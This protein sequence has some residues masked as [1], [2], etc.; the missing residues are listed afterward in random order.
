M[1]C[2]VKGHNVDHCEMKP[3]EDNLPLLRASHG[4]RPCPTSLTRRGAEA[5]LAAGDRLADARLSSCAAATRAADVSAPRRPR[6]L[7]EHTAL[8]S[9]RLPVRLLTWAHEKNVTTVAELSRI[10]PHEIL[11]APNMGR[12]T[13][14]QTRAVI[15]PI[16]GRSWEQAACE[17]PFPEA[18]APE[19]KTPA[20]P[21]NPLEEMP[22]TQLKLP[23]RILNWAR[24][25]NITSVAQ[26]AR[27]PPHELL[28]ERNLGRK[29]IA[30][31]RAALEPALGCTWEHAACNSAVEG[32]TADAAKDPHAPADWDE[33]RRALPESLLACPL[34]ELDLPQGVFFH[35]K[36]AGLSTVA[37]LAARSMA[38]LI[39]MGRLRRASIPAL[40]QALRAHIDRTEMARRKA[41]AGLIP[42]LTWLLERQEP[43]RRM[44]LARRAGLGGSPETLQAV[45]DALGV[46]RERARQLEAGALKNIARERTWL[47]EVRR[48]F[49][50]A[51][52]NGSVAL[53]QLAL[54][55]RW[56]GAVEA[57]AT[58]D[59]IGEKILGG[60]ARV[61]DINDRL[62]L[63]RC[64][65]AA[66]EEAYK[67]LRARAAEVPLPAPLSAFHALTEALPPTLDRVLVDALSE[68][69]RGLLYIKQVGEPGVGEARVVAFGATNQEAT[70]A[71]L[72]ASPRPVPVHVLV[73]RVGRR[74]IPEEA[75]YFARGL[76]GHEAHFPDF[77]AWV[78]KLAPPA[79]EVMRREPPG[80][81]WAAQELLEELREA[82]ELPAWLN[83]WHLASILRK[84]GRA[85]Y[86]GWNR[87][88]TLE[89]DHPPDARSG[90]Y[91]GG[92]RGHSSGRAEERRRS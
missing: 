65:S 92:D 6:R 84:S 85:R 12:L 90:R 62:Y 40:I 61:L 73:E 83:A 51:L 49:D 11:A 58:I 66:F 63:A 34:D 29:T 14:A 59:Y 3:A 27:I 13:I 19:E 44:V 41:E 22:L 36:R 32:G 87:F 21:S 45:A 43:V 76:V 5:R 50:S 24:M 28:S 10:P 60:A 2:E 31:A 15:E 81:E 35:L 54:D 9:L 48:L 64:S 82:M 25:K 88:S 74:R 77:R 79:V 53:D 8:E 46:S 4:S 56:T 80:R 69:L 16:L 7:A 57:P 18:T 71:I 47:A 33:M 91:D 89:G 52:F 72:R 30:G 70:L 86:L 26:L 68:R 42:S 38:Q 1:D 67:G 20:P 17:Q 55:P 78:A 23:T 75:L 39:I 37:D